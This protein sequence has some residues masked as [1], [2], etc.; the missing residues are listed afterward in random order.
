[1]IRFSE[2]SFLDGI[3]GVDKIFDADVK[4]LEMDISAIWEDFVSWGGF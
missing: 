3:G 2:G 4:W 1:M